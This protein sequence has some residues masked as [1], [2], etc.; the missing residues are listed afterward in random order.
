MTTA[1]IPVRL[2]HT[3]RRQGDKVVLFSDA[4]F[5]L[6]RL[7]FNRIGGRVWELV[8][9]RRTVENIIDRV[10]AAYPASPRSD[11]ESSVIPFLDELRAEWLVMTTGD[12][13]AYE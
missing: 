3:W 4:H 12:L 10:H 6:V 7:E 11:I 1:E 2:T 13:A 9:G 8:D 5:N